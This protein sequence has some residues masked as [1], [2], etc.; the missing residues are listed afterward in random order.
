MREI[1]RDASSRGNTKSGQA[2]RIFPGSGRMNEP[3]PFSWEE[4]SGRARCLIEPGSGSVLPPGSGWTG[5]GHGVTTPAVEIGTDTEMPGS[6][7]EVEARDDTDDRH[8]R[9]DQAEAGPGAR[10]VVRHGSAGSILLLLTETHRSH[11]IQGGAGEEYPGMVESQT[12][13]RVTSF[14]PERG[15]A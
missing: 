4:E 8:H 2:A 5:T 6:F 11:Q 7:G 14:V 10:A 13:E 15:N 3:D 12:Q 9:L 1:L